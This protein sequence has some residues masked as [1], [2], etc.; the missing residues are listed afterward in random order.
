MCKYIQI[1]A[2]MCKYIDL[3]PGGTIKADIKE[4]M[5]RIANNSIGLP[6]KVHRGSFHC[7]SENI[8]E[9]TSAGVQQPKKISGLATAAVAVVI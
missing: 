3:A 7:F 6:G 1:C 2:N 5:S 8:S 4:G 9:E